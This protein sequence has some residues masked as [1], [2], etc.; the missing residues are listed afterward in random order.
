MSTLRPELKEL[1]PAIQRLP[2]D[3]RGYP[4]PA[5]VDTINGERDFRFMS[6]KHWFRCLKDRRCWVCDGALGRYLAFVIGPM[7][8]IT[9]TTSEP[10]CHKD[11]AIWSA[12]FCP[13]LTRPRM[14][15]REDEL[16]EASQQHIA[17]CPILRNPG[18]ACVWVAL[19]YRAWRD[20]SGRPLITVGEPMETLWFAEG[21]TATRAEVEESI[22]TGYPILEGIAAEQ[23]GAVEELN[24]KR[25]EIE[26][27]LP[28]A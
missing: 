9:R 17:G 3:K 11:C 6:Q 7:C 21:R 10:P 13:F 27:L 14:V 5:F 16:T 4:I 18:V 15:R 8:T 24:K 20:E 19:T 23:E 28:V 22:R 1:P 12:R 2:L 26:R 25:A